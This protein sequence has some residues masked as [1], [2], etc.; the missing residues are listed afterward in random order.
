MK[1]NS[2]LQFLLETNLIYYGDGICFVVRVNT[3][4]VAHQ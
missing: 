3:V 4:Y 1:W 2:H